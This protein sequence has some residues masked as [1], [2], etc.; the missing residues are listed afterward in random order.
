MILYGTII[1]GVCLFSWAFVGMVLAALISAAK[2]ADE[3]MDTS[4]S[5][6]TED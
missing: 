1:A 2:R 3:S 6:E 5:R 4:T